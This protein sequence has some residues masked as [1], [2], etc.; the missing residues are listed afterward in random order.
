MR[1]GGNNHAIDCRAVLQRSRRKKHPGAGWRL[2]PQQ[3]APA[4]TPY[5]FFGKGTMD[6]SLDASNSVRKYTV[7]KRTPA[8]KQV[9]S[10][11]AE[12]FIG[13]KKIGSASSAFG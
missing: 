12:S 5:E 13:E 2:I 6:G 11:S 3:N 9:D 10:E 1:A 7:E 8:A 4:S